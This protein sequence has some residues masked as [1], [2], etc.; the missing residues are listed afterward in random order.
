MT[1][2]DGENVD[3]VVISDNE[4]VYNKAQESVQTANESNEIEV[5]V[6]KE[7]SKQLDAANELNISVGRYLA[8]EEYSNKTGGSVEENSQKLKDK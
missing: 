7:T 5:C 1:I 8:I 6:K 3:L 2:Q 4:K